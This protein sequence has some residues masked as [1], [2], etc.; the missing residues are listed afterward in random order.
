MHSPNEAQ[1]PRV[2]IFLPLSIS[3]L[4]ARQTEQP[5]NPLACTPRGCWVRPGLFGW[6]KRGSISP[7]LCAAAKI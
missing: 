2:R 3:L 7:Q 1:D 5:L 6:C 4:R